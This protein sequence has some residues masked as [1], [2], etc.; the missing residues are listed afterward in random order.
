MQENRED[1]FVIFLLLHTVW[2]NPNN[3]CTIIEKKFPSRVDAD[4][5]K[6]Q[7][8]MMHLTKKL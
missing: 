7:V 1:D 5:R 4:L 2:L 6:K 8:F 3:I